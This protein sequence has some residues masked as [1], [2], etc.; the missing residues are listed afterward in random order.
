MFSSSTNGWLALSFEDGRSARGG[1]L[2]RAQRGGQRGSGMRRSGCNGFLLLWLL[3]FSV[4]AACP[5]EIWLADS[6]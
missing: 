1:E 3:V 4:G 6:S 2:V 5:S